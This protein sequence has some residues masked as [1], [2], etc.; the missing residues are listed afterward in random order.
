[1]KQLR[2]VGTQAARQSSTEIDMEVMD[3]E[4]LNASDEAIDL[5]KEAIRDFNKE[6]KPFKDSS[7]K[8]GLIRE[9]KTLWSKVIGS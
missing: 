3:E 4:L 9:I 6:S 2:Q 1:M 8:R 7:D 5:M